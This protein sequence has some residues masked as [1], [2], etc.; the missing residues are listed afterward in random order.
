MGGCVHEMRILFSCHLPVTLLPSGSTA[1]AY[2]G[3][4]FARTHTHTHTRTRTR[5]RT[6]TH[7]QRHTNRHTCDVAMK[8]DTQ[9]TLFF[10][11]P[12]QFV[13]LSVVKG[14]SPVSHGSST[15]RSLSF[16]SSSSSSSSSSFSE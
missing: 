8:R 14:G 5:T 16:S 13:S 2:E 1:A 6:R 9:L 3:H 12:G 15:A 11:F 10:I 7:V 4:L